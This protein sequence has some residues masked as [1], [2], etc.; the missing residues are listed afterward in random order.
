MTHYLTYIITRGFVELFRLVPFRVLYLLSDG[1]AFLL[2]RVIRYRRPV[3]FENLERCFPNATDSEK[4]S[5]A[6]ASY[7]N[8]ADIM[9]ESVKGTTAS[10]AELHRRYRYSNYELVNQYLDQGRSVVIA[11]GHYNN[12]EW[13]VLT[14]GAGIR[15]KTIGIYKPL[16]NKYTDQWFFQTRSRDGFMILKSMKDTFRAVEEYK[17]TPTVFMLVADQS[18][19]NLKTAVIVDFFGHKTACLPGTEAIARSN[20]YVVMYYEIQRLKRGY[21]ELTFSDVCQEPSTMPEGAITQQ[22]MQ[23]IETAIRHKPGPWLWSH[24]RWK[25]K[26]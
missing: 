9:L 23:K 1:V 13:G 10:L 7:Q 8:L 21:Y 12:W 6:K 25:H 14:I 22:F 24:R 4:E 16:S 11:G 3:V 15:G 17:G 18:P 20:N 5:I 2:Y 26:L 19:S